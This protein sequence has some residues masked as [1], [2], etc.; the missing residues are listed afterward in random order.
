MPAKLSETMW[1]KT[2]LTKLK[3]RVRSYG[4]KCR[5][6][7]NSWENDIRLTTRAWLLHF[8]PF[9]TR[10]AHKKP[11]VVASRRE[12]FFNF[13]LLCRAADVH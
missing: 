4:N 3:N 5:R 11:C 12:E 7:K 1:N 10:V 8:P 13:I 2:H 9:P 6:G